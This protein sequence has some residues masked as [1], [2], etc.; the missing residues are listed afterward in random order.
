MIK[1][2]RTQP[3]QSHKVT[4]YGQPVLVLHLRTRTL[5]D[6]GSLDRRLYTSPHAPTDNPDRVKLARNGCILPNAARLSFSKYCTHQ[7]HPCKDL[8]ASHHIHTRPPDVPARLTYQRPLGN[9]HCMSDLCR[10]QLACQDPRNAFTVTCSG[11]VDLPG[12]GRRGDMSESDQE[13]GDS[14][15]RNA[16]GGFRPRPDRVHVH[17]DDRG[18]RQCRRSEL[19]SAD[20]P[21][22]ARCT[23]KSHEDFPRHIYHLFLLLDIQF[24]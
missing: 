16:R 14:A 20:D 19:P 9:T 8:T 1:L 12:F 17:D 2:P 10:P 24:R 7:P 18:K 3:S 21:A 22:W 4:T 11:G 6:M 23:V 13:D 5:S 15:A